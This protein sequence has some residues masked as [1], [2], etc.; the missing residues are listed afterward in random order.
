LT[1]WYAKLRGDSTREITARILRAS[2]EAGVAASL[3][4]ALEKK[5]RESFSD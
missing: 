1:R 3:R 5:G 4:R 2:A